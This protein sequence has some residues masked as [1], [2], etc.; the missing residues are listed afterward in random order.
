MLHT[1][2]PSLSD[3]RWLCPPAAGR[4][5]ELGQPARHEGA[6]VASSAAPTGFEHS[7]SNSLLALGLYPVLI[8]PCSSTTVIPKTAA[9]SQRV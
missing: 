3:F 5:T 4:G 6:E 8:G 7:D 9:L 2:K 1:I